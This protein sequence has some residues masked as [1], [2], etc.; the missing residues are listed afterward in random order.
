MK[1][2]ELEKFVEDRHNDLGLEKLR[3]EKQT[4]NEKNE[5]QMKVA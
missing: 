5:L 2:K 4:E 1:I 3:W